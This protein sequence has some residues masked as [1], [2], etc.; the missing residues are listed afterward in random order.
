MKDLL[1]NHDLGGTAASSI[2]ITGGVAVRRGA[3]QGWLTPLQCS[4][5][6]GTRGNVALRLSAADPASF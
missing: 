4:G 2:R 6:Q 5:E 3:N 1:P